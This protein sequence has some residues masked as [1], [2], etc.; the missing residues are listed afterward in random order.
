MSNFN[1]VL[2]L[3]TNNVHDNDHSPRVDV[4]VNAMFSVSELMFTLATLQNMKEN[5][6]EERNDCQEGMERG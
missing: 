2:V 4:N 6:A 3:F 5:F 1:L